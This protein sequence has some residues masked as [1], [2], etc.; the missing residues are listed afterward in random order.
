MSAITEEE[1]YI[2]VICQHTSDGHIIPM[3]LRFCDEDGQY[4]TYNVKAYKDITT[5]SYVMPNGV[6]CNGHIWRFLC[7]IQVFDKIRT[8]KLMYNARENF[9]KLI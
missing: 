8:V 1:N 3:R 2:D 7:K 6:E 9:W 4:Q 5:F